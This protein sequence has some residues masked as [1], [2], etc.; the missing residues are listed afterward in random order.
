MW[1]ASTQPRKQR[2]YRYNAPLHILGK[3]LNGHLCKELREKIKT[4]SVRLRTGDQVKV[5]RGTYK[6]KVGKISRVDVK[7]SQIF[8]EGI[9]RPKKEGGKAFIPINPNQVIITQ[10]DES[11]K[12]RLKQNGKKA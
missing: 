10:L 6:N 12:R 8:V 7:N 11:N 2:K 4:R 9:E 3:F 1:K 5:I